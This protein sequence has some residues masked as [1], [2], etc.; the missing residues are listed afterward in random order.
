[1]LSI[2]AGIWAFK[3]S[4]TLDGSCAAVEVDVEDV[5][6][7]SVWLS[8]KGGVAVELL[9]LLVLPSTSELL[10]ASWRGVVLVVLVRPA[11]ISVSLEMER[12]ASIS[13]AFRDLNRATCSLL[14]QS[15]RKEQG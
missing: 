8:F 3:A 15:P 6:D 9:V 14:L 1:M 11:S 10:A 2:K 7:P 12:F 5:S 13:L 4:P